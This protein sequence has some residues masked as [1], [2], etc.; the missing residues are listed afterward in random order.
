MA[1]RLEL[2]VI[3]DDGNVGR[4]IGGVRKDGAELAYHGSRVVRDVLESL[5]TRRQIEP[6]A[7]FDLLYADPWC[8]AKLVLQAATSPL[9]RRS[10]PEERAERRKRLATLLAREYVR[11][12]EGKFAKHGAVKAALEELGGLHQVVSFSS[13]P[14][15]E[16]GSDEDD[17]GGRYV[18]FSSRD[19]DDY[20]FEFGNG[21]DEVTQMRLFKGEVRQL[22]NEMAMAMLKREEAPDPSESKRSLIL[23]S[24]MANQDNL[25]IAVKFADGDEDEDYEAGRYLDFSRKREGGGYTLEVGSD[26]DGVIQIEMTNAEFDAMYAS[27]ALTLAIDYPDGV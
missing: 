9:A 18:D 25:G 23:A 19:G 14:D 10:T 15:A 17:S 26:D 3:D 27:L 16:L 4:S 22:A 8:N 11:D 13:N 7:A 6:A 1:D 24:M 21:D 2:R 20:R 12:D 5:A